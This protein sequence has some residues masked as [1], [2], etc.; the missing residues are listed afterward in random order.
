[1]IWHIRTLCYRN[2]QPTEEMNIEEVRNYCLSLPFATERCPFG[3]DTLAFEIGGRMFCLMTLDGQWDF[4]NLKVAPDYGVELC[5]R[6]SGIRP[7]YHMNKRHWISVD[8]YG[9]VPDK[10]QEQLIYH[11]YCQTAMKLPKKIQAQLGVTELLDTLWK[12][13]RNK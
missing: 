1:C 6:F 7:G 13:D 3:P 4:Y 10:L 11:S 2:H 8:F 5:E 9:D 12:N